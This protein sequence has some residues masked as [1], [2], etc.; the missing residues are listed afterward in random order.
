MKCVTSF[1]LKVCILL[2]CILA[3]LVARAQMDSLLFITTDQVDS[4]A[5]GEL[6][7]NVDNISL[8]SRQ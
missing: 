3:P 4:T 2:L 5:R 6:R 1:R 7:L 8:L